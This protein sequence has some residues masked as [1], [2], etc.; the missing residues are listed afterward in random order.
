MIR[1]IVSRMPK[2]TSSAFEEQTGADPKIKISTIVTPT[3]HPWT[4]PPKYAIFQLKYLTSLQR[5]TLDPNEQPSLH[6]F[7]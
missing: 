6:A 3:K 2:K 5:S 1:H 7:Q 4:W